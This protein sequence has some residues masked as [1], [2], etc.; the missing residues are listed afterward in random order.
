MGP[1]LVAPGLGAGVVA[2][3]GVAPSSG[4]R[5]H[6]PVVRVGTRNGNCDP[7]AAPEGTVPTP[8]R[9][10]PRRPGSASERTPPVLGEFDSYVPEMVGPDDP[11][12]R[13]VPV[14]CPVYVDR[15][16]Y[17]ASVQA[18]SGGGFEVTVKC[19]DAQQQAERKLLS[20]P[21]RFDFYTESE[22]DRARKAA[23]NALRAKRRAK[24]RVRHVC[25]EMGA[26]RLLTLTTREASNSPEVMLERW[27]RFCRLVE[28]ASGQRFDYVAVLEEHPSNRAHLH[29]HVAVSVFLNVDIL[30]RCWWQVCGGR[31]TGNVHIKRI[32]GPDAA[33][34]ITRVASYISKYLTKDTIVR[35]HKKSY[36]ASRVKLAGVRRYWLKARTMDD[37]LRELV[38]DFGVRFEHCFLSSDQSVFWAYMP[39]GS[40]YATPF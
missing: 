22:A 15:Y 28:R 14:N 3:E 40:S 18:F 31:A 16:H 5:H 38:R 1:D 36:W 30:R 2:G 27:Q 11:R 33:K 10:A 25:K 34:R 8:S 26:D 7:I 29:F 19:V 13:G 20:R 37:V 9:V 35:R 21:P 23:E 32:G 17:R 12:R 24:T 39:P 6:P 4:E